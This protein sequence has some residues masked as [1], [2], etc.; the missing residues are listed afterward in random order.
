MH[1][2][3]LG[4]TGTVGSLIVALALAAGHT[5]MA[6]SRDPVKLEALAAPVERAVFDPMDADALRAAVQGK[7]A[8]VFALGVNT[9]GPTTFF[10]DVTE[11]LVDSMTQTGVKRLVAITGVGAGETKGHGGFLYDQ[12]IYRLFTRHRYADKDK[13]EDLIA[14][15]ALDWVIVRPAPFADAAPE[16]P[17]EVHTAVGPKTVLRRIARAEVARFVVDQLTDDAYL[18]QKPFIGHP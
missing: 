10:S 12:I 16:S 2:L 15:S 5:V 13:Q 8:V 4:A 11:R 14:A 18:H 3:I 7:D 1:L 17:L 6:Q 9:T